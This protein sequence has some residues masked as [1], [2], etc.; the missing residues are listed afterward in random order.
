MEILIQ[1]IFINATGKLEVKDLIN[2]IPHIES[3]CKKEIELRLKTLTTEFELKFSKN[4]VISLLNV[5][6]SKV[7]SLIKIVAL[8]LNE[9]CKYKKTIIKSIKLG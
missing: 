4:Y 1:Y 9:K 7:L 2:Q 3:A 5:I 8:S 6:K